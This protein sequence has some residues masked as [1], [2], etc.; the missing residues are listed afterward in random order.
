MVF[1]DL[2][3]EVAQRSGVQGVPV[4]NAIR[5]LMGRLRSFPEVV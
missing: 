5:L 4:E 3:P 2:F 1:V